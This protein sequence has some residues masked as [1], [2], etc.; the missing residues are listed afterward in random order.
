MK[1]IIILLFVISLSSCLLPYDE[2]IP[3]RDNNEYYKPVVI[4]REDI[5]ASI[6][7][8][9]DVEVT[10]SSK[11]YIFDDYIFINDKRKGFHIFDNSDASNPLKKTFLNIP[12]ATDIAIR[13]NV[14]FVN[15]ATDLVSLTIDVNTT[16]LTIN[17]RLKN[18]FP[19]ILSPDGFL[20]DNDSE[21]VIVV[22]WIK[23]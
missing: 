14:F 6:T 11:I 20:S 1:K 15:Q 13:N 5:D 7:F 3:G 9:N 4:K 10:E 16:A 21:E 8:K 17:K 23:K 22:D 2:G 19:E 12:G 18:V